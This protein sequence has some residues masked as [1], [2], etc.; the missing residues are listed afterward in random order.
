MNRMINPSRILKREYRIING[1][2]AIMS[3]LLQ[4]SKNF[5]LDMSRSADEV[6]RKKKC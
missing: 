1:A 2:L 6:P 4:H 5:P 3:S